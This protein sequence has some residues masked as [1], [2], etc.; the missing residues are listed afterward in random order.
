MGSYEWNRCR[1]TRDTHS[2]TDKER[3]RVNREGAE[4]MLPPIGTVR[5]TGG[6]KSK[7]QKFFRLAV[8]GCR[9]RN[10]L[11]DRD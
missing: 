10:V 7:R 4:N 2:P 9:G 6:D 8:L 3:K 5:R 11:S 1:W